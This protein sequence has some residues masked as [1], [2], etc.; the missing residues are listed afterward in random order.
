M[1][2]SNNFPASASPGLAPLVTVCGAVSSLDTVITSPFLTVNVSGAYAGFPAVEAP[3]GIDSVG[4][5]AA[6][7]EEAFPEEVPL[8]LVALLAA[9]ESFAAVW[10][11]FPGDL[12]SLIPVSKI[13]IKLEVK[14]SGTRYSG[15]GIHRSRHCDPYLGG[16]GVM[17]YRTFVGVCST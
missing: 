9:V 8:P 2:V 11:I 4:P 10:V 14:F 17:E 3:A 5:E 1:L 12:G 6:A 13:L 16:G 7:V 15:M